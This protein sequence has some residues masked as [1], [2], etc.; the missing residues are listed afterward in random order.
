M[1][2]P[3]VCGIFL[4][5][6]DDE[7]VAMSVTGQPDADAAGVHDELGPID[8]AVIAWPPGAPMTGEGAPILM[9]LVDKGIVRIFDMMFVTKGEDG[10]VVG[11][12]ATGLSEKNVGEF[13][14]FEGASSGLLGDADAKEAAEALDD[15][16]SAAVI[17]YENR[18]VAPFANAVR[19]NGGQLLDFQ[20]ITRAELEEVLDATEAAS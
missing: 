17:V 12:E 20:R 8:V 13:H 5:S 14:V 11:F 2:D 7:E 18:W 10:S 4:A 15:G 6:P 3:A 16:W 19:R 9:D 1:Q